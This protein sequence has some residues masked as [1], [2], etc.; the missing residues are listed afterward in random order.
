MHFVH[1]GVINIRDAVKN[2]SDVVIN[3]HDDVEN[4]KE[5][6]R[7]FKRMEVSLLSLYQR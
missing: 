7:F 5:K 6:Q 1:D 4:K 2:I 3:I